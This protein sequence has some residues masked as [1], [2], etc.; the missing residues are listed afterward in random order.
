MARTVLIQVANL[1][2]VKAQTPDGRWSDTYGTIFAGLP[3]DSVVTVLDAA[4]I[5]EP[6]EATGDQGVAHA[7]VSIVGDFD[8]EAAARE[9]AAMIDAEDRLEIPSESGLIVPG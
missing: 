1:Q 5:N 4:I 8:Y 6:N 2:L 3:D 7:L 9:A